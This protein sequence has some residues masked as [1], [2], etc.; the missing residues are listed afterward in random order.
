VSLPN[1]QAIISGLAGDGKLSPTKGSVK[2]ARRLSVVR[3]SGR[4]RS[5][6][7]MSNGRMISVLVAR[8]MRVWKDT[9]RWCI[10]PV[11]HELRLVT[12]LARL[13]VRNQSFLDFHWIRRVGRRT[14]FHISLKDP[15]LKRGTSLR[16]LSHLCEQVA[17]MPFT[18]THDIACTSR[19]RRFS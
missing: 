10:D 17:R 3:R 14:R 12:L 19:P 4:W 6:L 2:I 5:R 1:D 16:D 15:W 9:L 11:G 7:R 13:D 18:R 8:A